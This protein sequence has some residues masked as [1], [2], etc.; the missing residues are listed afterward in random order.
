MNLKLLFKASI[1]SLA[2]TIT[3]PLSFLSTSLAPSNEVRKL[4]VFGHRVA[5]AK[6]LPKGY[7]TWKFNSNVDLDWRDLAGDEYQNM[8]KALDEAF[9]RSNTP[10]EQFKIT[11][12]ARDKYGKTFP[13]EW[14]V[15]SGDNKGAE[16]NLDDPTLIPTT[17]GPK[18]PH[19]GYQTPGKRGSG[20]AVRG[21]IILTKIPVSRG[22]IGQ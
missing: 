9:K 5:I 14:R 4:N 21:H 17:E 13:V 19:V 6:E 16:V 22:R 8:R 15:E 3:A 18:D 10:K 20:G 1:I 11:K 7:G 12:D 2:I